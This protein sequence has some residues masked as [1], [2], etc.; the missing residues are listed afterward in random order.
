MVN[1]RLS[2]DIGTNSIGWCALSLQRGIPTGIVGMGVRVFSDGRNPQSGASNAVNRRIARS[3]RR[4]HDRFLRRRTRLLEALVQFGLMPQNERERRSLTELDPYELRGRGL[5]E[6][7]SAHEIGRAIFHMNQRRGFKSNRKSDGKDK[8]AGPIKEAIR[9]QRAKIEKEGARTF[10]EFLYFRQK[11]QLPLRSRPA[12]KVVVNEKGKEKKEDYYEFFPSRE[13][14]EAEFDAFW[15]AQAVFH[16]TTLT[17]PAM[18]RIRS[19][20]FFQHPLK[21]QVVGRCLFEPAE[22]RAPRAL[23][24]MQRLRIYQEVNN[25]HLIDARTLKARP[26]RLDERDRLINI[27][28]TPKEKK[29]GKSELTFDAMRKVLGVDDTWTFTHESEKRKALEGDTTFAL[30]SHKERF[31]P[32][33]N[34]LDDETQEAIVRDILDSGDEEELIRRL[35]ETGIAREHAETAAN[36]PLP[37]GYGRLGLTAARRILRQLVL[38]VIPYSEA[39]VRAGYSS[40]SQFTAGAKRERLPYYGEVLERHVVPDPEWGGRADASLEKRFGKV[41]NPSVHIALNQLRRV[42]NE[43]IKIYGKPA[44]IHVEVLRDLKNSQ[45]QKKEIEAEQKKNQEANERCATLLREEFNTRVNRENIRRLRLYETLSVCPYTG[46]TICKKLLFSSQVEIDH[47]LPFSRTLDDGAA[48]KVLCLQRANREK[49]DRTPYE[50]W[51]RNAEQWAAILARISTMEKNKRWRFGEDAMARY[52]KDRDFIARQLTDSQ[53][54]ARLAREYLAVLFEPN[55][56]H[57][58]VCLP[59]RLTGMFRHHL[60]LVEILEELEGAVIQQQDDSNSEDEGQFDQPPNTDADSASPTVK[61]GKNRNDHRHHAV[62]ALVVGL[63][64]R[65]FLQRAS[66]LHAKA[67]K[68]GT[69]DFLKGL[70]HP[71]PGFRSSVRKALM[72]I[73]VSHKPDHG[74]EDQLHN[75]TA[76]GFADDEDVRGNAI[77]RQEPAKIKTTN[78]LSIKSKHLRAELVAH[79]SG[80]PH[81]TVFQLLQEADETG[82]R[83]DTL[84]L[85]DSKDKAITQQIQTFFSQRGIRRVRLIDRITLIPIRR[86][87]DGNARPYKGLKPDGNAYLDIFRTPG[88]EW[89][90]VLVTI[91]DANASKNR[92]FN[93]M[94]DGLHKVTR[95]FNRDMLEMEHNG[96][97]RIF[98]IQRMSES[99]IALAEHYEANTDS[100]NRDDSDPFRFVYKGS[101]EL[102]RKS[103][104]RFLTVTP[105]GRIRYLSDDPQ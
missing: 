36:T 2:L 22:E 3:A 91:F 5:D 60:G 44:E 9:L 61:A 1:Y 78:I 63:M 64:D 37:E 6:K 52:M 103:K 11:K 65:S 48:N 75:G 97:R 41:M 39:V 58:V 34:K 32:K 66:S 92:P 51:G 17:A 82:K 93:G 99:Q 54:I 53:Y 47:I 102:L 49:G 21:P 79:L 62:D 101:V 94:D 56:A 71:W 46:E 8:E 105:A 70:A 100:R 40:H 89:K 45:R 13:L 74:I 59:G 33:W 80:L 77:W 26:L 72:A 96:K 38:D 104:V 23:P 15:Q 27:M 18:Q 83:L 31:G 68:E 85:F 69:Y 19:I 7:L 55:E 28:C 20:I 84:N 87:G 81:S 35:M 4:T 12:E 95:L 88:N 98:Y 25:L 73:V 24:V 10:G 29:N 90:G 67:E 86:R 14:L 57:K 42:I 30:L 16:P 50:A 76:Y 43:I